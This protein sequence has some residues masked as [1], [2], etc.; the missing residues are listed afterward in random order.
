M[1]DID[2]VGNGR[3]I[4]PPPLSP[5]FACS[6]IDHIAIAAKPS[7]RYVP[8]KSGYQRRDQNTALAWMGME[9]LSRRDAILP[10]DPSENRLETNPK[11]LARDLQAT[12]ELPANQNC[13]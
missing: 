10:T 4:P 7:M 11:G 1:R 9:Q 2:S 13:M 8:E 12:R 6:R 3:Y 5:P